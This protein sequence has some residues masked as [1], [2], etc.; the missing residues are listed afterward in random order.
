MPRHLTLDA[1]L[2]S[3]VQIGDPDACWAFV[4]SHT[5]KGYGQ[6]S[7]G[8]RGGRVRWMTHRAAY[9]SVHGALP[10]VVMHTC[11]N[12]GCCNPM[13]LVG[14]TQAENLADM[15]AKGRGWSPF[16]RVHRLDKAGGR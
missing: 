9:Y 1:H 2:W 10:P 13:H 11:D 12:P 16:S 4:G 8:P 15:W 6:F 14:G 5:K 3:R 7:Q